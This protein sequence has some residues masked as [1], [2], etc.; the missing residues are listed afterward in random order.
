MKKQTLL[1][2]AVIAGLIFSTSSC[3]KEDVAPTG[4][5]AAYLAFNGAMRNLWADHMQ[6]TYATVN[7]FYNNQDGLNASLTRLLQNQKDIGN[8]IKPYFGDAAGDALADLL[9]THINQA[10]PVLQA[11]KDN[12]QAALDKALADW[13]KNADDIAVFLSTANPENWPLTQ[14]KEEMKMHID[15]TTTYA[16]DL[17]KK[18]YTN[19][20]KNYD[21]AYHHMMM[22]ADNLSS[23]IL[24]KFPEKF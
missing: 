16:V 21:M 20:I 1:L 5:S 2:L 6:F 10:V 24:A 23:G 13:Y 9:T 22:L 19:A 14:M 11:A 4:S 7:S 8:A 3:K 17:L 15:Q 12:N 18:D